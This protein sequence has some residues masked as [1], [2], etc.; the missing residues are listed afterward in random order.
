M[1]IYMSSDIDNMRSFSILQETA[2]VGLWRANIN[3]RE[4]IIS[5]FLVKLFG[6]KSE[7]LTFDTFIELLYPGTREDILKSL[8]DL[9]LYSG[10]YDR[11]LLLKTPNG[12]IPVH[13]RAS[14]Q[15]VNKAGEIITEGILQCLEHT[16]DDPEWM[17]SA[18]V[19]LDRLLSWQKSVTQ[20]L[21]GLL[22]D[23]NNNV[24]IQSMLG[25]ILENFSGDH[26]YI[27]SF[28]H[29]RQ[30]FSCVYEAVANGI[31]PLRNTLQEIDLKTRKEWVSRLL[32][33]M[34]VFRDNV[35]E[36]SGDYQNE[37]G[38]SSPERVKSSMAAPLVS[39]QDVW[40][41]IKIDISG[42]EK[43][44]TYLDIESF[45]A[46]TNVMGVSLALSRSEER[47]IQ[48]S[49]FLHRLYQN[50]PMGYFRLRIDISGEDGI[51]TDYEYLDVNTKF[52]EMLGKSREQLVGMMHSEIGPIF[53]HKL[54]LQI[55]ADVAYRGEIYEARAQLRNNDR[56]YNVTIYSPQ[57]GDVVALSTDVTEMVEA[58]EA[59]KQ[60][61]EKFKKVYMHLPVGI[62]IYD[63]DGFMIEVNDR[64]VAIQ[65]VENKDV[66]LGLNLFDH[67]SLPK[68]AYNLLKQGKDV[69]F[70]VNIDFM[71]VNRRYYGVKSMDQL[72]YL[73]IK[74]AVLHNAAGQVENYLLII[75][76]NTEMYE[77][78]ARLQEFESAFNSVAEIAEVGFFRW[79]PLRN[80]YFNSDQWY[81]NMGL[82]KEA[83]AI[84][85]FDY[86]KH[87][88][89]PSDAKVMDHFIKEAIAGKRKSLK[90]EFRVRDGKKWKWL[91]TTCYVTEYDPANNVVQFIGINYNISEL[92]MTEQ[93]LI[94]AK[95]RAEESDRLKSAFLANMSHEIRTPLNAIVGFSGVLLETEEKEEK[96]QYVSLIKQNNEQLLNLISDI[97]DLSKIEAG[98]VDISMSDINVDELCEQVVK[99]LALKVPEGVA[100]RFLRNSNEPDILIRSDQKRVTQVLSNLLVNAIKFTNEGHIWLSYKFTGNEIKF[101]VEDTG[102]GMTSKQV[103]VIF[104]RFIK[105]NDFIPGTGLGLSICKGIVDKLGGRIG[106]ESRKG[107]G[108]HFWFTLPL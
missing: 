67:P 11:K 55:L 74:C 78:S 60:S 62:E 77:T 89:Y 54:D 27:F 52:T 21:L 34:P 30:I 72:K 96:E 48:N 44:W 105:L 36:G 22:D 46:I 102:I 47:A 35:D 76:D 86:Y 93:R 10:R 99:S 79:N 69:T 18:Q 19:S 101:S 57:R 95:A 9:A 100:L 14:K 107:I 97:L 20:T 28:D 66:L 17:D 61:E 39:K 88:I 43:K 73:T 37:Y 70:D 63:K 8:R 80:S 23:S 68:F 25:L 1:T 5:A 91:R 16:G 50:M 41:F 59:L 3:K 29:K 83:D 82:K 15:E 98:P 92:K 51:V 103:K 45:L 65:C 56:Y 2:K 26:A 85:S 53:V 87:L 104:G 71:K 81:K 42:K 12:Y 106:V 31:M 94:E 24:A 84:M 108:S 49:E 4:L 6:L 13:I 7:V 32:G 64:E 40:G 58:T 90:Y 33:R 75:I 38:I